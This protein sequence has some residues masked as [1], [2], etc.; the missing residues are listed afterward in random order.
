MNRLELVRM[1][2]RSSLT[3]RKPRRS[4]IL[5]FENLNKGKTTMVFESSGHGSDP[6]LSQPFISSSLHLDRTID[7]L[8]WPEKTFGRKNHAKLKLPSSVSHSWWHWN[9]RH[10]EWIGMMFQWVASVHVLNMHTDRNTQ[11]TA[12][13]RQKNYIAALHRA[14]F[15]VMVE[16]TTDW[17]LFLS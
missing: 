2:Q 15:V 17:S 1:I 11:W 6:H 9:W 14:F 5:S 8:V 3:R 10:S 4:L 16:S 7:E 13:N 12:V